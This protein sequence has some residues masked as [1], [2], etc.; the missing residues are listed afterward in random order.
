MKLVKCNAGVS[1]NTIDEKGFT[2]TY[3]MINDRAA[4][5]QRTEKYYK[6]YTCVRAEQYTKNASASYVLHVVGHRRTCVHPIGVTMI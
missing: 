6:Y 3:V 1:D 5:M 4:F 2:V